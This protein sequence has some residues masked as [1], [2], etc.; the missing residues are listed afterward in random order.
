MPKGKK[1]AATIKTKSRA[2]SKL[3]EFM[4]KKAGSKKAEPDSDS[5]SESEDDSQTEMRKEQPQNPAAS[6]K[7]E[8]Q[9]MKLNRKS[10]VGEVG[11]KA[12]APE[13]APA[14]DEESE[15]EVKPKTKTKTKTKKTRAS[16]KKL[17]IPANSD[18]D[19]EIEISVK[20][21][22]VPKPKAPRKSRA[23]RVVE[24]EED[25]PKKDVVLPDPKH[26]EKR[27]EVPQPVV[28]PEKAKEDVSVPVIQSLAP[29]KVVNELPKPE[30][31]M[32]K[33]VDYE[34]EF[35]KYQESMERITKEWSAKLEADKALI[36]VEREAA[37]IEA[38]REKAEL[39][40]MKALKY[41]ALLKF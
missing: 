10:E 11:D 3:E 35:K 13:A 15:E 39:N 17:I 24:D 34:G 12:R 21:K 30:A 2:I 6:E 29:V 25:P 26:D 7:K 9:A 19:E 32:M 28:T 40:N 8:E 37:R 14:S 16:G 22:K 36:R 18:D 20:P 1:A 41:N 33:P 38:A 4:S 5:S 27:V 23:K 31:P